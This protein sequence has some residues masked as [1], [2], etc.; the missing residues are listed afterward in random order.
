MG[1]VSFPFSENAEVLLGNWTYEK[2]FKADCLNESN[3]RG[4]FADLLAEVFEKRYSVAVALYQEVPY[5]L[6]MCCILQHPHSGQIWISKFQ[7][8]FRSSVM[9]RWI[10][11]ALKRWH[12]WSLKISFRFLALYR[13]F[14]KP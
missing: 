5:V 4:C 14:R 7:T 9:D 3:K 1:I 8:V 10:Y 2:L 6:P 11:F 13:L 12:P